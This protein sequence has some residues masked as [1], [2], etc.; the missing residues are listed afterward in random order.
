MKFIHNLLKITVLTSV[1]LMPLV[2]CSN[3]SDE[4]SE[5]QASQSCLDES[6]LTEFELTDEAKN[7]VRGESID[8]VVYD[9][10]LAPEGAFKR[11]KDETGITVNILTTADTGTM[12]S[13]AVLTSGDPVGDVM[14]GIDNTFLC[15][16]LNNDVFLPYI[17]S[18][19]DELSGP[20]K[21]DSSGRV[22][23][24]DYGDI[25]LNYWKDSFE[26]PPTSITDLTN[27]RFSSEFVTQNPE[28]S[29]PGM[30]FLLSSIAVFGDDWENFW[31][32][33]RSNDIAIRSGWSEAYYEDFYSKERN[34]VTSYATS[35]VAEYIFADPPVESPP[36]AIIADSCFRS[37]EFTGILRGT[38][39]P[40]ASALLVDFLTSVYFQELIPETNFVLPANENAELPEVF[41]LFLEEIPNAVTI[42]PDLIDRNRNIWT[43]RWTELVLR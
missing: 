4:A 24:V 9:A 33:L 6:G 15:R 42:S 7:S 41:D 22:T 36:T 3:D 19:W 17:P 1:I 35:P 40:A 5:N 26:A 23:P 31:S 25:C 20:L 12:V 30:G 34:I 14:F 43:A 16:A 2:S 13:Q 11:F 8:L 10:F 21:L 39:S 27:S 28:T 37:V 18:T 38:D 29:A 32:E